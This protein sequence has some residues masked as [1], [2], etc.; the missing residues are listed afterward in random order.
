MRRVTLPLVLAI[1]AV[2]VGACASAPDRHAQDYDTA[3]RLLGCGGEDAHGPYWV[4][5]RTEF[6]VDERGRVVP[7][8]IRTE[9]RTLSDSMR[10]RSVEWAVSEAHQRLATCSFEPALKEGEPV[11][12]MA[13][14]EFRIARPGTI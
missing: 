10:G 11:G 12:A 9:V 1:T 14:H 4:L 5:V 7:A 3:P 2:A 8:T 6:T 13:R